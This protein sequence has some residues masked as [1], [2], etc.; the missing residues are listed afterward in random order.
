M[1]NQNISNRAF[2][3]F[4]SKV[5]GSRTGII[6]NNEMD[7]FSTPGTVNYFGVPASKA[8]FIA[9]WKRPLSSMCPS[10]VVDGEGNVRLVIGASGGTRITTTT[11]LVSVELSTSNTRLL[12]KRY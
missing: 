12:N 5:I 6:F 3:S 10:I 11:A 8:N 4:G 9:P 7:D 1:C 2:L